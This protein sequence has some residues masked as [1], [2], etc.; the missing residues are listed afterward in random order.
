MNAPNT[1][2]DDLENKQFT[3]LGDTAADSETA[4]PEAPPPLTAAQII[5]GALSAGRE[6]FCMVTKLQSPRVHLDDATTQQLGALWGP[7]CE[8]HHID[9]AKYLGDYAL[10]IAAVIGSLGIAANLRAAVVAEIIAKRGD[11]PKASPPP[12]TDPNT[13]DA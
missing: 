1:A 11:N 6:V 2:P 12:A 13:I 8:K 5:A 10:E 7:V 9:L 3:P 4:Q